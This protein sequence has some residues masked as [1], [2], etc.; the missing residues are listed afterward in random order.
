MFKTASVVAGKTS[1][2][3]L[4]K[5]FSP[6]ESIQELVSLVSAYCELR[7]YDD[8]MNAIDNYSDA[9]KIDRNINSS[10]QVYQFKEVIFQQHNIIL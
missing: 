8:A 5:V 2:F 7:K 9:L 10:N 3:K 6:P 1:S 4:V